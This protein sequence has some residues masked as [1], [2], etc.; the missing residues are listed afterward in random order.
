MP[1]LDARPVFPGKSRIGPPAHAPV[2]ADRARILDTRP[3]LGAMDRGPQRH[4]DAADV[5]VIGSGFGGAVS[6]LRLA[7]QGLTVLVLE[8]GRRHSPDDLLAARRDPRR[9]LWMPGLGLRGFFWQRVLRHVGIIGGAGVG[10]GSIVWAGVLLEPKDEF[11]TDPAWPASAAGWRDELAGH[12][13]TASRMLGRETTRHVGQMDLHL[14]ATARSMGADRT[15]GP[16]P[17]AIW[18]GEEGVTV[19][20][21]Y[22]DGEGPDRTGC[23]LCGA[24]LIGCPYGSKNALD[25]NYLWLAE[26][27]GARIR[28]ETRVEA[29]AELPGGGY[30]VRAAGGERFRAGEVVLAAGVL[31]TVELLFRSREQGLLPRVSPRLGERVRTNSEAITA[32]LADDPRTDLTRGPTISSEF[33]PDAATHVTQNRYVGGWHMRFQLGPLVD[34]EDPARR[35]RATLTRLARAPWQQVRLMTARNFIARLSVFT[36]MQNVENEIR[37]VFDRSPVRPWRRVLRSR[38][39]GSTRAPSYLPQANEVAR[40]FAESVGGRPLNLLLESVGGKSITAHVLGGASMGESAADGVIDTD[41]RVFGHPGLYVVDGSAVPANVG[42][43]PSLTITAMAERFAARH[44]ARRA[45]T[46]SST[47]TSPSPGSS[48]TIGAP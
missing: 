47:S 22:F 32:V 21:P 18:F 31:G 44:A 19:P 39:V 8:Q 41:H 2:P 33:Y 13:R 10:G 45:A 29:I 28:P 27:R 3:T 17:M 25:L 15:Y 36:V 40:R 1:N 46:P 9:Y 35:R 26:K 42:V 37:L 4:A 7:E 48:R 14:Q 30:E 43:N 20:D 34:G 5:I 6:A 16:T 11:F 12:Y 24:C 38:V 23:R